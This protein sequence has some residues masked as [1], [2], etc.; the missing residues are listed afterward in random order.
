MT[1]NRLVTL[2]ILATVLAMTV[3]MLGAFTRLKDAGLGCPDWPG[4]YG[5][6]VWPTTDHAI[7]QAKAAF[8]MAKVVPAKAWPEMVHRYFAGTLGLFI[9]TLAVWSAWRRRKNP[10][11]AIIAPLL[12]IGMVIFQA[13]L[14]MW[15]VTWLLLP[16]VVMGHLLGGMTIAATLWWVSL[17]NM[18]MTPNNDHI[19]TTTRTILK[20]A[21]MAGLT[22]V[23]AQIFLGGWTSANY[24]SI[25]CPTFP[26]CHGSLFPPMDFTSAFNF[27]SPIGRN[28]EGGVLDITTRITIQMMHRYGAMITAS[29]VLIFGFCLTRF[30][31]AAKLRAIGWA[32]IAIITLQFLLGVANIDTKLAMPIAVAHNG[33][34]LVLLMSMVTLLHYLFFEESNH[35]RN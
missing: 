20:C 21:A 25:I 14:G 9:L 4:C 18:Q 12:L 27:L 6:I 31:Q 1:K 17:R 7:S 22:I 3:V 19:N 28:Y 8:P 2:S 30:R 34:A 33:V 16:L 11:Q 26:F 10:N 24:A 35:Q 29:Y 5:K 32:L 15:T 13:L 23:F